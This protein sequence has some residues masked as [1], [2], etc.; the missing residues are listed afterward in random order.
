V[1]SQNKSKLGIVLSAGGARAAYQVGVLKEIAAQVDHFDPRLFTGISAGSI[2]AAYLSQ[3]EPMREACEHLFQLW[4]ELTF[5]QVFRTNFNSLFRMGMRWLYDLSL[6]KVTQRL[7]LK[8][9]LDASPLGDTLL[10]HVHFW[11]VSRSIR[12][13]LID[14]LAITAT[15]YHDG[16]TTTFFDSNEVI[17][18]WIRERRLAVRTA[19]RIRHVM[20]SCS[21]PILFEP[22][23]IGKYLFGDGSLRFSF[24]FSPVI[25]L[26]ATRILA[27]GIRSPQTENPFPESRPDHL[28]LG[29]IAGSVLNSIFLDSLEFDY[30]NLCR[31][32]A[33]V[34]EGSPAYVPTLLIR[35]SRDLG[36]IAR[37]HAQELPFHFRQLI[38]ATAT[39]DELG[40]LLSYLMFSNGY[41]R[42]L[43]ELGRQDAKNQMDSIRQFL[44]GV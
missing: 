34:G 8:S 12:T 6:S 14:G 28:S 21:I 36:A 44:G 1:E 17:E 23:P 42:A 26:G 5:T 37:E 40:D 31:I 3:G 9:L 32:N 41:I 2:N 20:A 16:T 22:I 13:G 18:P 7:L 24:P 4:S 29:F 27:V 43:L 19:L 30:E 38:S 33:L 25:H 11:K 15:N 35:P 10:R 39:P